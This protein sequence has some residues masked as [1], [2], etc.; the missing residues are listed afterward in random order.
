MKI[1]EK[2]IQKFKQFGLHVQK[3][4]EE[5]NITIKKLAE[6]TGIRKEYLHKIEKGTA[7]GVMLDKHLIKIARA[8]NVTFYELFDFE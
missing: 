6:T 3:L 5:R 1:K 4:R 2:Y 8:L 7:Y